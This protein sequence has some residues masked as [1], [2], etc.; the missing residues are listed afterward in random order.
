MVY[1]QYSAGDV[2]NDRTLDVLDVL[3]VMS[4][5][6]YKYRQHRCKSCDGEKCATSDTARLDPHFAYKAVNNKD[7]LDIT[8]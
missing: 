1:M 8:H 4:Q 5:F 6:G 2:N 3:M 7:T